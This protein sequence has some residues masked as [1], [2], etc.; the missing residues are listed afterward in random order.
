[1]KENH[2]PNINKKM[3]NQE[4]HHI[5]D[6]VRGSII[7]QLQK[8]KKKHHVQI[9]YACESGSRAW[10][11]PSTDSDYDVRFIYMHPK[12]WYLSVDLERRRDVIELPI[13]NE[14][15]INGWDLRKALQLLQKSNPS[16]LEWLQSPIV[17]ELQEKATNRLKDLI[18]E[19]YSQQACFYHYLNM[20]RGNF[21]EYL[22]GEEVWLKKYFYVLRPILALQWI[23]KE[24]GLAPMKFEKMVEQ[25]IP[26]GELK[27]AI[28][29]LLAAKR[30]GNELQTGPRIDVISRFIERELERLQQKKP[31]KEPKTDAE[32][33]NI[34]FRELLDYDQK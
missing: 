24:N 3:K 25:L 15:D 13:K 9:L 28:Q 7:N 26:G 27:Q 4:A 1:V 22:K 33:I 10:G 31:V 14:L 21:R 16:L 5:P 6:T 29:K 20:A 11:F 19:Y 2:N 32:P 23:E 12:D 8:I 30:R 17:Y 18:P 34:A